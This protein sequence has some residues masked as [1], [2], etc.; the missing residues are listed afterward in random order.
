MV[1]KTER[2]IVLSAQQLLCERSGIPVFIGTS[3]DKQCFY[4]KNNSFCVYLLFRTAQRRA[5]CGCNVLF[6]YYFNISVAPAY[7]SYISAFDKIGTYPRLFFGKRD[8]IFLSRLDAP[9]QPCHVFPEHA[10]DLHSL[11]ITSDL[12]RG[13][14]VRHIPIPR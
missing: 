7:I 5:A 10:H 11:C 12:L 8:M 14:A 9:K 2:F 6:L 4:F 13:V 1:G 3:V